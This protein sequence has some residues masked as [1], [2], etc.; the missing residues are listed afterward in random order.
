MKEYN[1]NDSVKWHWGQGEGSGKIIKV[2]TKSVTRTIKGTKVARKPSIKNPAYLIEQSD[3][4]LVLKSASEL[5]LS[6]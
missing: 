1:I 5:T 6:N 2:Y 3:G 4:D